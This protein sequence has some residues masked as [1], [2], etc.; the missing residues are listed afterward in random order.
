MED[1]S[2]RGRALNPSNPLAEAYA[3]TEM[4]TPSFPSRS[5]GERES[6]TASHSDRTNRLKVAVLPRAT[7]S[8]RR[9]AMSWATR[10]SSLGRCDPQEGALVLFGQDVEEPVGTLPD[11]PDALL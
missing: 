8:V 2:G 7:G 5:T 3:T 1:L 9:L 10:G 4:G 11:I 6:D